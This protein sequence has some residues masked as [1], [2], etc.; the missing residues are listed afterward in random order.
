MLLCRC[1]ALLF[2]VKPP[3]Q[4]PSQQK[5]KQQRKK[6][7]RWRPGSSSPLLAMQMIALQIVTCGCR[8]GEKLVEELNIRGSALLDIAAQAVTNP[9]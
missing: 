6:K 8:D 5:K 7:Q 1:D 9:G 4:L 2:A 3:Q